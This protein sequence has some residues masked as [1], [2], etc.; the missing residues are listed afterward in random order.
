MVED[1]Y[2]KCTILGAE[3]RKEGIN[4]LQVQ[5]REFDNR[6]YFAS[7][8]NWFNRSTPTNRFEDQIQHTIQ[9]M[10]QFCYRNKFEPILRDA[11]SPSIINLRA[12]MMDN[13]VNLMQNLI[14]QPDCFTGDIGWGCMIRTGQDILGNSLQRLRY[15]REFEC[16]FDDEDKRE[17]EIAYDLKPNDKDIIKCFL[18]SIE[19]PFSIHKFVEMGTRL[20]NIKPGEWFGPSLTAQVIQK[21]TSQYPKC[22]IDQCIV[23]IDSA[24]VYLDELNAIYK[25]NPH[26]KTLVL[27]CVMLGLRSVPDKY[28][29]SIRHILACP[30][31][32]GIAGGK[33]SSSYYFIGF[34]EDQLIYLDPH[35]VYKS[36]HSQDN[37]DYSTYHD[38]QYDKLPINQMDPSMMIGFLIEDKLQWN[39]WV[40]Y[41]EENS[42]I[43]ILDTRMNLESDPSVI[44]C[45]D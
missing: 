32:V 30:Q 22:G 37:I 38:G 39:Q 16:Y 17:D 44:E 19:Y 18:D 20:T 36:C 25:S 10:L 3:F 2:C 5:D 27:L 35:R 6:S 31:S 14:L 13:P 41:M 1:I 23:S 34:E 45:L 26:S 33:P 43:N 11:E 12:T 40:Q 42:I 8:T 29:S 21:L 28:Q 4:D 24:N 7:G 15:G 9:N